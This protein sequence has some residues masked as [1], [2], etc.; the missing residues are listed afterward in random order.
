MVYGTLLITLKL[1][2]KIELKDQEVFKKLALEEVARLL[3]SLRS[4][5]DLR[6]CLLHKR[7]GE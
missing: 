1:F 4:N 6:T 5:E 2:T 7:V 3:M